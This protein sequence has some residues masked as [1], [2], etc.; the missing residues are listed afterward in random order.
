M[1]SET[2]RCQPC[3]ERVSLWSRPSSFLAVPN[4]SSIA[5]RWPSACTSA[6]IPVPAGPVQLLGRY[7]AR[8]MKACHE[9]HQAPIAEAIGRG[10]VGG[11]QLG[12]RCCDGTT[13]ARDEASAVGA[14]VADRRRTRPATCELPCAR[15]APPPGTPAPPARRACACSRRRPHRRRSPRH[16]GCPGR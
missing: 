15:E 14:F 3:Q 16:G 10:C 12:K 1:T 5:R 2:W 13:A 8:S 9:T 4:P 6:S 11:G 7:R